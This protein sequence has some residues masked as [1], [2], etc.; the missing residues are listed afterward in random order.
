MSGG[1]RQDGGDGVRSRSGT[2]VGR[3]PTEA[4]GFE[5]QGAAGVLK[6]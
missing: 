5:R 2:P 4:T 1:T 3:P 6:P